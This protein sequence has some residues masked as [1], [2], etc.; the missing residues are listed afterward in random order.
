MIKARYIEATENGVPPCAD[1]LR[2]GFVESLSMSKKTK[3]AKLQG[4]RNWVAKYASRLNKAA[5]HPDRNTY[6]RH[7]KHRN[8]PD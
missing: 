5:I 8:N 2:S 7:A 4:V 1:S 6:R 3:P